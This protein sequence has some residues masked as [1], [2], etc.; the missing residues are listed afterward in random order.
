ME[1]PFEEKSSEERVKE[2][3]TKKLVL[4]SSHKT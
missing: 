2:E 4:V 3:R 1:P